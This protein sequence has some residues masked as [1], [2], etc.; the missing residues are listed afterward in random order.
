MPEPDE[1]LKISYPQNYEVYLD[2]LKYSNIMDENIDLEEIVIKS[3]IDQNI[4][5][6]NQDVNK[7]ELPNIQHQNQKQKYSIKEFEN[8]PSAVLEFTDLENYQKFLTAFMSLGKEIKLTYFNNSGYGKLSLQDQFFLT[9]WKLRKYPTDK[10]LSLHF[11]IHVTQVENIFKT[12]ISF[13]TQQ[14]SQ[15]DLWPSKKLVQ[16]YMPDN[17]KAR[18]P[19][20]RVIIDGTEFFVQG[21]K[22]PEVQQSKFSYYK[23]DTTLKTIIGNLPGGLFTYQSELYGGSASDRQI[24]ERSTLQDK[25]E[26]GDVIMADR[27]F[28]VQDFFAPHDVTV[29]TPHFTKGKGR[30]PSKDLM[31]D[32]MFAKFRVHV[33]RIIGLLKTYKIL[34][35]TLKH[36]YVPLASEITGVCVML[37]NFKECIMKKNEFV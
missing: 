15:I 35:T 14:W 37:C 28:N 21:S 33:E 18:F 20:T 3:E 19:N 5:A 8:D 36:N 26:P 31:K 34:S 6:E 25:C 29:A 12:W 10:E 23:N 11:G 17:F 22:N 30:L 1:N 2:A 7:E 4:H 32:R 16:Y 24:V 27:G 9:L 13:M